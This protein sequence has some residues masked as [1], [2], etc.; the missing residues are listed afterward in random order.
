MALG[1]TAFEVLNPL[2]R[3][4]LENILVNVFLTQSEIKADQVEKCEKVSYKCSDANGVRNHCLLVTNPPTLNLRKLESVYE[5]YKSYIADIRM[6]GAA[7]PQTDSVSSIVLSFIVREPLLQATVG[8]SYMRTQTNAPK[9]SEG[10]YSP[11]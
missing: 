9:K 7:M 2:V 6:F 4:V 3:S 1:Q 5:V 8:D 11:Y 10:R